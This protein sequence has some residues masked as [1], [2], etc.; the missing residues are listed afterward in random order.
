M[1]IKLNNVQLGGRGEALWS[2]SANNKFSVKS[3]YEHLTRSY[4]GPNYKLIWKVKIPL[5]IKIFM[6]L[7]AQSAILT[8]DNMEK[9]KWQGDPTCYFCNSTESVD[10]LLFQCS[11][12][13]VVWGMVAICFNQGNR[14]SSYNQ[15]WVWIKQVLP[16]E[17]MFICWAWHRYVGHCGKLIIRRVLK[18]K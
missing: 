8:K 1:A 7:V 3:L 14:P 11:T 13:R 12:A 6:W 17:K 2:F 15:F 10:H 16:G 9:R 4:S 18:R 5:K